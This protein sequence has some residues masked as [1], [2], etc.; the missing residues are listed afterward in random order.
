M[1]A[2]F[3]LQSDGYALGYPGDSFLIRSRY[4]TAHGL[5]RVI[6]DL[7]GPESPLLKTACAAFSNQGCP[8]LTDYRTFVKRGKP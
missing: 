4:R 3:E 7:E 6:D 1:Q 5:Q 2:E 8:P